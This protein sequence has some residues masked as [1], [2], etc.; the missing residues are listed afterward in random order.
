MTYTSWIDFWMKTVESKAIWTFMPSGSVSW[1]F[2][3]IAFRSSEMFSGLATACL[4]TASGT[5]LTPL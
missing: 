5:A 2:G 4:T 3:S 1:I